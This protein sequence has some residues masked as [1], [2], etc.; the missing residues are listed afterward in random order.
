[1]IIIPAFINSTNVEE[2]TVTDK[3][4]LPIDFAAIGAVSAKLF[5]GGG[6]VDCTLAANGKI[7]FIPGDL[8]IKT[9]DHTAVLRLYSAGDTKG[10][11]IAGPGLPTSISIKMNG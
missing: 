7:S 2:L 1:M 11:V 5:A 8:N 6:S 9:M 10:K 4:G 3:N